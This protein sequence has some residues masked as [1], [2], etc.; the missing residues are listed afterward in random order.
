[1]GLSHS[2]GT[3]NGRPNANERGYILLYRPRQSNFCPA[4][5]R[6]HWWVGRVSA[7]CVFCSM[8]LPIADASPVYI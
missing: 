5:G 3:A 1:M 7:E 4:C 2:I 8:A 6:A